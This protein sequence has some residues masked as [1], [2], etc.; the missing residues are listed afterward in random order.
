MVRCGR[1]LVIRGDLRS[2]AGGLWWFELV[3][4]GL[5]LLSVLVTTLIKIVVASQ[6]LTAMMKNC[7]IN[8]EEIK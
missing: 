6:I 5:W 1:L 7:K 2:F 4:G 8:T 3:C